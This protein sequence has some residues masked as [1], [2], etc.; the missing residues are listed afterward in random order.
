MGYTWEYSENG[1]ELEYF[2]PHCGSTRSS[3]FFAS[4]PGNIICL[5]CALGLV[6]AF[7][8]AGY[9]PTGDRFLEL[10]D[11]KG[12]TIED[13][14]NRAILCYITDRERFMDREV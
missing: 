8:F 1:V 13:G 4:G 9:F 3:A 11:K 12:L 2:C 10:L 14:L 6:K 5:R 7:I